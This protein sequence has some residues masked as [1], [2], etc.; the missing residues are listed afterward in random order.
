MPSYAP[1]LR[2][3]V[4][5][6]ARDTGRG[7]Q[8]GRAARAYQGGSQRDPPL[9]HQ[10]EQLGPCRRSSACGRSRPAPGH[11]TA[12]YKYSTVQEVHH[13]KSG[14]EHSIALTVSLQNSLGQIRNGLYFT[15]QEEAADDQSGLLCM[16]PCPPA[17]CCSNHTCLVSPYTCPAPCHAILPRLQPSRSC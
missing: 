5:K 7:P 3:A 14:S 2:G 9:P 4:R 12:Q 16:M 11:S 13:R 8:W 15:V 17:I 1:G 6:A 10:A